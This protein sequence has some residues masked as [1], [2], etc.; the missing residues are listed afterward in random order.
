MEAIMRLEH[1]QTAMMVSLV[2]FNWYSSFRQ[3]YF[4]DR[5][6]QALPSDGTKSINR[7]TQSFSPISFAVKMNS[8]N[9]AFVSTI[10]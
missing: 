9:P 8:I 1:W 7:P 4:I 3:V 6:L 5:F 10:F 2:C